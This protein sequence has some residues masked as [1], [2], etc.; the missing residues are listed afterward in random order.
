M[1]KRVVVVGF[2]GAN[3]SQKNCLVRGRKNTMRDTMQKLH[4]VSLTAN[5]PFYALL[6]VH[7]VVSGRLRMYCKR[8]CR[9]NDERENKEQKVSEVWPEMS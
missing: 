4:P 6:G 7:R 9:N 5:N 1:H 2:K 8:A 3:R